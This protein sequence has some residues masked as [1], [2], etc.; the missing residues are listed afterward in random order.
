MTEEY[1]IRRSMEANIFG[2]RVWLFFFKF[3]FNFSVSNVYSNFLICILTF[4]PILQP[5]L[6]VNHFNKAE[7]V[8]ILVKWYYLINQTNC[9]S[10]Y[11]FLLLTYCITLDCFD[12]MGI[13][14][15]I[16]WNTIFN[17]GK[18]STKSTI[19]VNYSEYGISCCL[20]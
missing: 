15:V 4:F 13:W 11:F 17:H 18:S 6:W 8:K 16:E 5:I 10:I 14:T 2:C 7:R 12:F 19:G 9:I 20:Y 1:P 3:I